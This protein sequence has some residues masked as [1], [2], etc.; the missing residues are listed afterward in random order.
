LEK[1]YLLSAVGLSLD[2]SGIRTC[3]GGWHHGFLALPEKVTAIGK[4]KLVRKG[5]ASAYDEQP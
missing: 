5:F 3:A 1:K 2:C 4:K